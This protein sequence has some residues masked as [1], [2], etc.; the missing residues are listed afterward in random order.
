LSGAGTAARTVRTPTDEEDDMSSAQAYGFIEPDRALDARPFGELH[1]L[2]DIPIYSGHRAEFPQFDYPDLGFQQILSKVTVH[3]DYED[4]CSA[5]YYYDMYN[6]TVNEAENVDRIIEV[7]TYMGGASV[8]L[9]GCAERIGA[10]LVMIDIIDRHLQFSYQRLARSFPSVAERVKLFCGDL[11]T[12]V[13]DALMPEQ[14]SSRLLVQLDGSH[15]FQEVIRD[16]G[17]LSYVKDRLI[18]IMAQ[19]TH[20]RGIPNGARFIDAALYGVFGGD[21]QYMALGSEYGEWQTELVTPNKYGGNYFM[22]GQPEGMYLPM[23]HN[24]FRYPHPDMTI[25]QFFW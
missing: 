4:Q 20:L 9:A 14:S 15:A 18:G 13:R 10:E 23:S 17:T 22:P 19:D 24:A 7:G 1:T 21:M 2:L 6:I 3:G 8:I 16:L 12:Y 11:P 5:K 25:D